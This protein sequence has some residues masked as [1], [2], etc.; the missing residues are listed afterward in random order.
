M[1]R[2]T[3][4]RF[5]NRTLLTPK[6]HNTRPTLTK[7]RQ[8]LF[9]SLQA[10]VPGARVLD[11]FAGS[12]ALGIEAL[13]RG[14][15]HATFVETSRPALTTLGANLRA[16]SLEAETLVLGLP[17]Q[18][19]LKRLLDGASRASGKFDLV[20]IDPP[21]RE[22][23]EAE[24]IG[25][26]PWGELLSEGAHVVLEW[27]PSLVKESGR[28]APPDTSPFLVKAR[29]KAYGDTWLTTYA[30]QARHLPRKL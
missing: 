20:L 15:V 8:A 21:Y 17:V 26:W 2:I 9:N 6:G 24:L 7:T 14:A 29:E 28:Q 1:I 4:G 12:G 19:A 3:A 30:F 5:K 25:S 23:F 18:T 22:G 10:E 13:S 11:L 27:S 16:L